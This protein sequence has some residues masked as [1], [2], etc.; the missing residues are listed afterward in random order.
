MSSDKCLVFGINSDGQNNLIA[1]L[2]GHEG[3]IILASWAHPQ[4]GSLIATAGIDGK[5]IFHRQ[6]S[7]EW[8]KI[9]FSEFKQTITSLS[10]NP[11]PALN[12]LQCAVGFA[13]GNIQVIT[14]NQ[15]SWIS[16]QVKAHSYGVSTIAWINRINHNS[17]LVT[18]GNDS[19]IKIWNISI[20]S[21]I[22]E[23]Q[24][25]EKIHDNSIKQV[26]VLPFEEHTTSITFV[27]LD[28]DDL[29]CIWTSAQ[30]EN[31]I[32]EAVKF[33]I[34]QKPSNISHITWSNDGAYLSI[35]TTDSTFLYKKFE[36]EWVIFSSIS[37]EGA[38][39]NHYEES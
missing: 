30:G 24:Q 4:F 12:V 14:Y 18:G 5:I 33:N 15:E 10:F 2:S 27:S 26:E 7:K 23:A 34:E 17:R 35:S 8:E 21:G 3:P 31:F 11:K 32:G 37:Q 28:I 19:T 16:N 29:I 20:K 25:L 13:D 39:V 38:F 9:Y 22:E 1:Q 36:D 6:G